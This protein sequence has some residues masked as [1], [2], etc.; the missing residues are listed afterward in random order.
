MKQP[1]TSICPS[2]APV[3]R[4]RT[5]RAVSSG[6]VKLLVQIREA[7]GFSIPDEFLEDGAGDAVYAP[8]K[9]QSKG[10]NGSSVKESSD[11]SLSRSPRRTF[12]TNT[13]WPLPL[14]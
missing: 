4:K 8:Y 7:C 6:G 13:G 11:S 10:R 3:K 1:R 9:S 2:A 5:Y 14:I 12:R